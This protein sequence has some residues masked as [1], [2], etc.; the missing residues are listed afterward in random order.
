MTYTCNS[1]FQ[2]AGNDNAQICEMTPNGAFW[3][4]TRPVCICKFI[5]KLIHSIA[6]TIYC[7]YFL[8]E[9]W[10]TS[11]WGYNSDI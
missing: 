1:G 3:T 11:K 8:W 2:V 6:S 9:P 5:L 10:H 4:P 7:S